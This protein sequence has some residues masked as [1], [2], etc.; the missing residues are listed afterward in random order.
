[1]M[2]PF[3]FFQDVSYMII[4]ILPVVNMLHH[5]YFDPY[6]T[7]ASIKKHLQPFEN[8]GFMRVNTILTPRLEI[9]PQVLIALL[10]KSD[11][12]ICGRLD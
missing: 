3:E 4:F 8:S 12:V 5:L 6:L 1:M 9:E 7:P 11:S 10:E 2:P